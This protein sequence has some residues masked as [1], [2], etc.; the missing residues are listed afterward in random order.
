M[1]VVAALSAAVFTL[2]ACGGDGTEGGGGS[3]ADSQADRQ[4]RQKFENCMKEH[5]VE[6]PDV[7]P[8]VKEGEQEI[9]PLSGSSAEHEAARA[10][11]AKFAPS[12]DAGEDVTA[13]D[14]DRALKKAECLR[15]QGID[16]KDPEPGT[17]DIT[18]EESGVTREKLVAAFAACGKRFPAESGPGAAS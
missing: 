4:Q 14:Q 10:A 12:Q 8:G 17:I 11:C 15:Q 7:P 2:T 9:V 6:L 18:V 5:G 13:A 3:G 16:A 1:L